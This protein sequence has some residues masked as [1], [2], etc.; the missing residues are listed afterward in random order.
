MTHLMLFVLSLMGF[1]ALALA[2]ARHQENI[3][4][5]LLSSR[6]THMLRI[7]GWALLGI[8]LF[9]AVRSQGWSFGLVSY[10]GHTS[11]A[12]GIV[13]IALVVREQLA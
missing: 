8:A 1:A 3:F 7:A 9:V 11:L 12:A 10:S 6:A 4:G 13:F 5:R 2:M